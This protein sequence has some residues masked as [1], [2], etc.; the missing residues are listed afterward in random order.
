VPGLECSH[1]GGTSLT[2]VVFNGVA[3]RPE[4]C[5]RILLL[6]RVA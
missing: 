1:G 2:A 5:R 3:W 6:G 4:A